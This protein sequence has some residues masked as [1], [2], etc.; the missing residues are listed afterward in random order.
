MAAAHDHNIVFR[1][2]LRTSLRREL[3]TDER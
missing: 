1:I 2:H 3:V